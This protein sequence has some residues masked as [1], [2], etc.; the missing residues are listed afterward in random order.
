M[1]GEPTLTLH[2]STFTKLLEGH[3][4]ILSTGNVSE[5][6]CSRKWCFFGTQLCSA[7]SGNLREM[8]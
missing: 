1:K 7:M 3:F 4:K 8:R 6:P 2:F 5:Y